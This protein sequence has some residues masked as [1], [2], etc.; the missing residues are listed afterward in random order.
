MSAKRLTRQEIQKVIDKLEQR[1]AN[2]ELEHTAK[3][4]T[5]HPARLAEA[6]VAKAKAAEV[7][8]QIQQLASLLHS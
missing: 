1:A 3:R 8:T 6:A 2:H 5:K 4:H 7:R